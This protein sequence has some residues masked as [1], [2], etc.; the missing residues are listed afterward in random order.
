MFIV[1]SITIRGGFLKM[2]EINLEGQEN[3]EDMKKVVSKFGVQV[4]CNEEDKKELEKA[5]ADV[6]L[7]AGEEC[8]NMKEVVS[9]HGVS[10]VCDEEA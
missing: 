7:P 10:V 9:K 8:E 4:V 2:T 3:C 6:V 1:I 5:N